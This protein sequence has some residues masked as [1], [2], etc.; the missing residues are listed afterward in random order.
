MNLVVSSELTC[1]NLYVAEDIYIAEEN[2]YIAEDQKVLLGLN[3][4]LVVN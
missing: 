4:K 1:E 2:C 3:F